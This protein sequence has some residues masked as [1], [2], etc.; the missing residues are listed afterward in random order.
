M[1]RLTILT[2][3][4]ACSGYGQTAIEFVRGI[5]ALTG[6][7]VS[8]RAQS[9]S[10]RFGAKIPEDIRAKIVHGVQPGEWELL[11]HHP[12]FVP[13]PGKK[14]A[15]FTMNESTRLNPL[16]VHMLNKA[17]VVIVPSEFCAVTF[18]ASG[19]TVPIRVVPLGF[20]PLVYHWSPL[21][22]GGE[23]VFG[24]AGSMAGGHG[25]KGL[26]EVVAAF[27]KA[28]P[29]GK[30]FNVRLRL[31][32]HPDRNTA[33]WAD[34]MDDRIEVVAAHLT[35]AELADWY[36]SL[37]CFVNVSKGEGFGLMP[38]QAMAC[39]R[40]VLSPKFGGVS[41]YLTEDN[42]Y[43]IPHTLTASPPPYAG[44]WCQVKES[45]LIAQLGLFYAFQ[46]VKGNGKRER[47]AVSEFT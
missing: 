9:V 5:E 30:G 2:G 33:D 8:I 47:L 25:R 31:K 28:F 24:A 16:S 23:I 39:G 12:N 34:L 36:A 3:L 11:I 45:E 38:L 29:R 37:T 14:T 15:Y 21:R 27:V 13:T 22:D 26:D 40:P 35:E 18:S 32:C 42:G 44:H 17:S 19:V 1:K 6:A 46:K 41:E 20:D 43:V 4:D 10:E 7:R